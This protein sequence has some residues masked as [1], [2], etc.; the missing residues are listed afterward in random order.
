[1]S[2]Q[3]FPYGSCFILK[4]RRNKKRN[5]NDSNCLVNKKYTSKESRTPAASIHN[6][7][8]TTHDTVSPPMLIGRTCPVGVST[9]HYTAS[10]FCLSSFS[11]LIMHMP[12]NYSRSTPLY[13][14]WFTCPLAILRPFSNKLCRCTTPMPNMTLIISPF[15]VSRTKRTPICPI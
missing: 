9:D 5:K 11:C 15:A 14:L 8:A 3:D 13:N 12:V 4:R 2:A 10:S 7:M 6:E 1:M